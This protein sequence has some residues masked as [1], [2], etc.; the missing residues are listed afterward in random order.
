[1]TFYDFSSIIS[2]ACYATEYINIVIFFIKS[3]FDEFIEMAISAILVDVFAAVGPVDAGTSRK[4]FDNRPLTITEPNQKSVRRIALLPKSILVRRT[5][6]LNLI[7]FRTK[8]S[9]I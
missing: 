4:A 3:Q 5:P 2:L 8:P 6:E 9:R 1:M 7:S